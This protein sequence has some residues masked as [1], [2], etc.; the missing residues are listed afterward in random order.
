MAEWNEISSAA[1]VEAWRFDAEYWKSSYLGNLETVRMAQRGG[2]EV[3]LLK[4]L[5]IG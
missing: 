4:R 3:R 5:F 2:L 1:L